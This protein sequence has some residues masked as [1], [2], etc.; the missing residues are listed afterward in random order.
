MRA[1][2]DSNGRPGAWTTVALAPSG[3]KPYF[4]RGIALDDVDPSVVY[5]ATYGSSASSGIGKVY[6]VQR[7]GGAAPVTDELVGGPRQAEELR[8]L[9]GHLYAAA[10][11]SSGAGVGAFRLADARTATSAT[12]WRRIAAGP[13]VTT[14]KYYGL[15]IYKRDATTTLWVTS[16]DAVAARHDHAPTSSCGG[17]PPPTTS[18]PTAPGWPCPATSTTRRTTSPAPTTRRGRSGESTRTTAGRAS[19]RATP[20][21]ASP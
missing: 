1:P 17:G 13:S 9:G 10:N 15:E 12:P 7:A 2:L 8:T 6:R 14:V 19:T 20:P 11:D 4:I 3:G 5:V 16:D 21:A 18:P